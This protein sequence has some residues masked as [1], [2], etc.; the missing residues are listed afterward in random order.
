MVTRPRERAIF[1]MGPG[2]ATSGSFSCFITSQIDTAPNGQ[3]ELKSPTSDASG[4]N[5]LRFI[6]RNIRKAVRQ[7]EKVEG[8]PVRP[9]I[10]VLNCEEVPVT[11]EDALKRVRLEM[12]RYDIDRVILL[13]RG[14]AIDDIKK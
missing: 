8:G 11:R 7:F 14:G 13:T 5:G 2:D 1:G 12:S 3:N 9:S 6:E 4:V 10:V